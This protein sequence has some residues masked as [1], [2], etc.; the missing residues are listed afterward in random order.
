MARG[1]C[2]IYGVG[3]VRRRREQQE[4]KGRKKKRRGK[5][6]KEREEKKIEKEGEERE[7]ER[8][9]RKGERKKEKMRAVFRLSEL[10]RPRSKVRIFEEG[11]TPRGRDSSY[12]SFFLSF[13]LLFWFAFRTTL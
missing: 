13:E 7:R 8:R 5:E 2:Y 11:Y 9:R 6:R 12:L 3:A 10:V 1:E 4:G